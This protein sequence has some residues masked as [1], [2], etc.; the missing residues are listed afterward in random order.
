LC[1]I[2]GCKVDDPI[3]ET[4]NGAQWVWYAHMIAKDEKD[5]SDL[6]IN[7]IEYL[8]SYWNAEAVKKVKDSRVNP[9]DQ[10]FASDTD[11]EEQV[12]SGSFKDNDIVKA[13]KDRYKNTNLHDN[14]ISSKERTRRLPK[15]LSGIRDLF[16]EDD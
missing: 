16:G 15:D 12:L 2:W 3:F 9:E 7:H 1:K 6:K 5:S 8:A 11:F 13:I 14:N 10:G 4:I